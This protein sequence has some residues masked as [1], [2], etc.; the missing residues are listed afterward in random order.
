MAPDGPSPGGLAVGVDVGG[1]KV[2]AGLVASDGSVL[3]RLRAVS[4]A[5]D[6]NALVDLIERLVRKL[7]SAGGVPGGQ[8]PTTL[9]AGSPGQ[10]ALPVGVGVAALVDNTGVARYAP[11]LAIGDFPL[12]AELASRLRV[13][14]T[15]DND[16]N[17][18][19]WGEFAAGAGREARTSMVMLTLGTGV[20]GGLVLEGRLV[21]GE[22]GLAGELGHIIVQEGGPLCPCGNRGC[23]EPL[24]SGTAIA[25]SASALIDHGDCPADSALL[26]LPQLTG[27]TVTLAAHAGDAAAQSVLA[28]CGFWLGVG[29]ASIANALDP[30][31]VVVGGGAMQGGELLLG[32]ARQS[33]A[34]RLV[35]KAQRTPAPVVRAQLADDAGIVG[36]A[37]LALAAADQER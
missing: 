33:F 34:E 37:I 20:G 26:S 19:A 16:A 8:R 7:A 29:I 17:A 21:R 6:A 25:R 2:A 18:A 13:P 23:L 36:A 4:P 28:Q 14:V 3:A 35:G 15:V 24:A 32:P 12:E 27:K 10:A 1:T 11:N 30:E 9:P 5:D 31:I 22:H